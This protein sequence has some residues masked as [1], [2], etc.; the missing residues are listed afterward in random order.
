VKK[1]LFVVILID[2]CFGQDALKNRLSYKNGIS[3]NSNQEFVQVGH[4]ND[5]ILDQGHPFKKP[6]AFGYAIIQQG[7]LKDFILD[8][9]YPSK[10]KPGLSLSNFKIIGRY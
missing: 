3:M 10:I 2:L 7:K 5:F 8:Q 1:F 4:I 6:S 9:G